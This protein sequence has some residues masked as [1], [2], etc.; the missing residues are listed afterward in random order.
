MED[1]VVS[2]FAGGVVAM[3]VIVWTVPVVL[4]F[5]GSFLEYVAALRTED[6]VAQTEVFV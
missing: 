1:C 6:V 5:W 4:P 3:E 2:F